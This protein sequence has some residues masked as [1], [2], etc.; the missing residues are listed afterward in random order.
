MSRKWIL[1]SAA[2]AGLC[3]IVGVAIWV[4]DRYST[5]DLPDDSQVSSVIA[6]LNSNPELA[7]LEIQDFEIPKK[8]VAPLLDSMRP[9]RMQGITSWKDYLASMENP[10]IGGLE[11]LTLDGRRINVEIYDVGQG[12]ASFDVDGR[13]GQR[14]G[15][16]KS[17]WGRADGGFSAESY[18][19]GVLIR[20][21]HKH[22][23]GHATTKL[24]GTIEQL[25]VSRGK[26]PPFP[27]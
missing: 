26:R 19:I 6:H 8:Y 3:L 23:E 20:E 22:V 27:E 24:Q 13:A 17:V 2:A 21:I 15:P 10:N 12:P 1:V 9:A 16:Y 14:R 25:E 7:F 5:I 11:I 4:Y 18:L